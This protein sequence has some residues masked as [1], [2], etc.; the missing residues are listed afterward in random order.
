M[1]ERK[2][3]RQPDKAKLTSMTDDFFKLET[4]DLKT[5]EGK[6]AYTAI[7]EIIETAE[8]NIRRILAAL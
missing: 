5:E 4:P 3:A 7:C 1:A 2:A 8:V 6:M